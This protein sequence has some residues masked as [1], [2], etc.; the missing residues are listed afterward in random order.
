[1]IPPLRMTFDVE[2][3]QR[4]AF[5]VWTTRIDMWWPADHTATGEDGL[6]IVLEPRVGGRIFQRDSVGVEIDWG[7]ITAFEPPHRLAYLWHLRADRADATD[8][9]IQFVP[10]DAGRTRIEI[11]HRGWERLGDGGTAWRERNHQGWSTLLPHFVT[12]TS[13]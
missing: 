11:E 1:M 8:V 2:C 3:D 13:A 9:E 6:R 12:A 7:E 5:E 4:H 10:I